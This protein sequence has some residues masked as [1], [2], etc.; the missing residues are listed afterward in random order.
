LFTHIAQ[1]LEKFIYYTGLF[2]NWVC[3]QQQRAIHHHRGHGRLHG[4][5]MIQSFLCI[6]YIPVGYAGG[7]ATQ[8]AVAE[9]TQEQLPRTQSFC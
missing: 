6:P 2:S 3:N 8:G 1:K 5:E 9:A 7:R 4:Q